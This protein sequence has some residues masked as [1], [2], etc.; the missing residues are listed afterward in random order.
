MIPPMAGRAKAQV[1]EV[2]DGHAVYVS[3]PVKVA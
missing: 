2:S 3:K 1:M